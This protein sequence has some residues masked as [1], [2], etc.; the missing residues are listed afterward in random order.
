MKGKEPTACKN[1]DYYNHLTPESQL[2]KNLLK[3]LPI[4]VI[5]RIIGFRVLGLYDGDFDVE[6]AIIATLLR[7][8]WEPSLVSFIGGLAPTGNQMVP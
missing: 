7:G 4:I 8:R 6:N 3:S 2:V 1:C 5:L